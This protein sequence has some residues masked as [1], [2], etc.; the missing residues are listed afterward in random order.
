[1]TVEGKDVNTEIKC[2]DESGGAVLI[3]AIYENGR[4]VECRCETID[5]SEEVIKKT[6]TFN[7]NAEECEVKAFLWR[8]LDGNPK[9][10][11]PSAI[12][13]RTSRE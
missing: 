11:L 13:E 1:M 9:P 3:A 4:L 6:L 10:I 12:C 7:R 8:G 5:M 2:P